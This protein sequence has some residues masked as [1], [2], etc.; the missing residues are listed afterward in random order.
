MR[1]TNHLLSYLTSK[2]NLSAKKRLRFFKMRYNETLLDFLE[3]LYKNGALRTYRFQD[4]G[5]VDVYLKYNRSRAP[6][7]LTVISTPGNR[8]YWSLNNL[9]L[10]HNNH[11]FIGFYIVSTPGGLLTSDECLLGGTQGG[12]ILLKVEI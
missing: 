1:Y 7:R 8:V 11:S 5:L 12:E 2:I 3:I 10:Y 4:D 9:S 6:V